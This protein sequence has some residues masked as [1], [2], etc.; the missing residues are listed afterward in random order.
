[1]DARLKLAVAAIALAACRDPSGV[2]V[3]LV[4]GTL[5]LHPDDPGSRAESTL[6][7]DFVNH[8]AERASDVW[9]VSVE[10]STLAAPVTELGVD[11]GASTFPL[12]IEPQERARV[13][14]E[15]RGRHAAGAPSGSTAA[16]GVGSFQAEVPLTYFSTLNEDH[17][18]LPDTPLS[19]AVLVVPAA[20]AVPPPA[21]STLVPS[22]MQTWE[23]PRATA[24][25]MDVDGRTFVAKEN[26]IV[27]FDASGAIGPTAAMPIP[28]YAIAA[29]ATATTVAGMF[30][31][32]FVL[33]EAMLAA[34]DRAGFVV[35]L[36]A[37]TLTSRWALAFEGLPWGFDDVATTTA[38]EVLLL[39]YHDAPVD[40]GGGTLPAAERRR[41][42]A[43]LGA[44]GAHVFSRDL[45][46]AAGFDTQ[47][48]VAT[49]DGGAVV[50]AKGSVGIRFLRLDA[51]GA[52]AAE[53]TFPQVAEADDGPR[54]NLEL[55]VDEAGNVLLLAVHAG[56]IHFG[57]DPVGSGAGPY[58]LLAKLS[59]MGEPLWAIQL[60][61]AVEQSHLAVGAG[62]HVW[63]VTRVFGRWT[64]TGAEPL[65]FEGASPGLVV[66]ELADDGGVLRA[67]PIA[68]DGFAEG[69]ASRPGHGIALLFDSASGGRIGTTTL[70]DLEPNVLVALEP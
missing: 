22:W 42:A 66:A 15:L 30:E 52:T 44:D 58:L 16:C 24:V 12:R 1:V 19:H 11:L 36:D 20:F 13:T 59:P 57:T 34:E 61:D 18:L 49:A 25:A 46:S 67:E 3:E 60:A 48:I 17:Q 21:P 38:D 27:S 41:L 6:T 64:A 29:G 50:A 33:D 28:L 65:V 5:T 69:M 7:I 35:Q 43:K 45:G 40:L 10:A 32:A 4:T 54:E 55:A 8:G 68:C 70:S 37:A 62:G 23:A 56:A 53:R 39:A 26:E 2:G 31:Q 63:A 9:L 51:T 14:L 47:A